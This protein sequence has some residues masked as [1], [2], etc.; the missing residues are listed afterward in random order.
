MDEIKV[1]ENKVEEKKVLRKLP[2]KAFDMEYMT[3]WRREV[4]FLKDKGIDYTFERTTEYGISQYK[5]KKTSELFK[6]LTEFYSAVEEERAN[7]PSDEEVGEILR[8]SGLTMYRGRN[9]NIKFVRASEE[10]DDTE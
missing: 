2:N 3:E 1:E 6:L 5:Y 10:K 8:K 4:Q 7:A 9:G